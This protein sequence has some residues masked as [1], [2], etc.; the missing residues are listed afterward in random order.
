LNLLE[1][2]IKKADTRFSVDSSSMSY[3]DWVCENT[4]LR[5]KPYS[6]EGYEFQ[7]EILDDLHPNMDVTKCSQVGMTEAQIR[8]M[9]AF[10][11]R[12]RATSGLMTFPDLKTF[13]KN[14]ATRIKPI[15]ENEA[16]FN[17][18]SDK[19]SIRNQALFQIN[20]SFLHVVQ[21]TESDATSTPADILMNDEVDLS[22][23]ATLALFSS[24]LQNSVFKITQRFSTPSFPSY[25]IDLGFQSSDQKHYM[26]RCEACN[27]WQ[28]PEFTRDFVCIP[29]LS[30]NFESF[31][32]IDDK[33]VDSLDL[34]A[35]FVQCEKCERPLNLNDPSLRLYV[36]KFPSR[37]H[38]RGYQIT[39]F[40]TSRLS[41]TYILTQMLS[42]KKRSNLRG[43]YNTVLGIPY[44]DGNIRLEEVTIKACFTGQLSVP[45]VGSDMPCC[46]GIDMGQT[47]HLVVGTGTSAE[48]LRPFLFEAVPVDRLAQ[49]VT[50]LTKRY[51]IVAGCIDR[52]PYTPDAEKIR[53]LTKGIIVPAQYVVTKEIALVHNEFDE[54]THIQLNRTKAIDEVVRVIKNRTLMMS[55]Y[56]PYE[57]VIIEHLRD[58]VRDEKPEEPAVW[59]KLTGQDHFFHALALM[60]A[61]PK[62]KE[63]QRLANDE[64]V[65]TEVIVMS[66]PIQGERTNMLDFRGKPYNN[67][68][69]TEV[70]TYRN[71]RAR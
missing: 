23:Q 54:L 1:D 62:A 37:K 43:F 52:L 58:M 48:T 59:T 21:C 25:G 67:P 68:I 46:I 47:C 5:S 32:E 45:D 53:D 49:R 20:K 29:G 66:A 33:T 18:P 12:N 11:H 44:T 16:V 63:L 4:T 14:S 36:A 19:Y 51:R 70:G 22:D 6:V 60:V 42:Y 7:R 39:P 40:A 41:P 17:G 56:G 50:D 28:H 2:F 71:G 15:V 10:L 64:E 69:L 61:A 8:K 13:T 24:R 35:S 9:L 38:H 30:D 26:V 3:T 27:H 55:G 34:T 31:V 57:T 65:R